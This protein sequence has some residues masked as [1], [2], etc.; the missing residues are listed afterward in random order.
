MDPASARAVADNPSLLASPGA[1]SGLKWTAAYSL[2]S[3]TLPPDALPEGPVGF[4]RFEINVTAAGKIGLRID[5][6]SG[7]KMWVG[8]EPMEARGDVELDLPQGVHVVTLQVDR[9]KRQ[10]QGLRVEL[11]EAKSQ[12]GAA[13]P[14][15]GT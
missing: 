3:G 11:L 8:T 12:A 7:L 13:Q 6:P 9:T 4:V 14:V 2:V 15:G 10:G 1:A 5:P